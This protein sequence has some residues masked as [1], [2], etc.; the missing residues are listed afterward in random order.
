MKN[1]FGMKI[2]E[3][4][5]V[6][7]DSKVE[8]V[9]SE[10][11]ASILSHLEIKKQKSNKIIHECL[12]HAKTYKKLSDYEN[13]A[14]QVLER[15]K[16]TKKIPQKL[17]NRA[18]IIYKQ[19]KPFV[20]RGSVLDLGCG[21]G[22]VGELLAKDGHEVVLADI[23]KHSNLKN[24]K[25]PFKL[26]RQGEKVP[27]NNNQFDNTLVLTVYHHSDNPFK[28]LIETVRVTKPRGRILVIES[29]YGV[30]GRYLSEKEKRK[31]KNYLSLTR[32]QQRMVNIFFDHFYNRVIHYSKNPKTKVNVPF[33]FNTPNGWRKLFEKHKLSQE[34][35]IHL[36]KDQPTVP[37]YHT[38]HILKVKK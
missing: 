25:L 34:K 15:E 8:R 1:A 26:F 16:V 32:E 18:K 6:F 10:M 28:T 19:I 29:V 5:V 12:H 22:K 2:Y 31:V 7:Q 9:I 27:F 24:I 4:K 33:N 37:E 13:Q 35:V 23:Y 20:L 11:F 36:G 3:V 30:R 17:S 21:D 14:H 38:L